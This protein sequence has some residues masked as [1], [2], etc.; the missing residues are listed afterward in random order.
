MH[1]APNRIRRISPQ[2]PTVFECAINRSSFGYWEVSFF[3]E[4]FKMLSCGFHDCHRKFEKVV[5]RSRM[6]ESFVYSVT[7]FTISELV[8]A[9]GIAHAKFGHLRALC[10]VRREGDRT[11]KQSSCADST[12]DCYLHFLLVLDEGLCLRR[13][14]VHVYPAVE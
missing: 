4:I 7:F 11:C 14:Q 9:V 8:P 2:D 10:S 6:Q 5:K 13:Y 1:H 3:P 12:C